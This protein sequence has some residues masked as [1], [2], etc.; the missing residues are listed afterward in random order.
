MSK[1]TLFNY[2]SKSPVTPGSKIKEPPKPVE[3]KTPKRPAKGEVVTPKNVKDSSKKSRIN[4]GSTKKTTEKRKPKP[5]IIL[6]WI[7]DYIVLI[8]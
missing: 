2:F 4:N 7:I 3:S 6:M 1:N 8:I 5:G